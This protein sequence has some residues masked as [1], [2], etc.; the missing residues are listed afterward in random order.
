VVHHPDQLPKVL[1][2]WRH[3]LSTGEPFDL[4]FPLRRADGQ[5]RPFLTRVEPLRDNGGEILLWLGTN[6]DISEQ[7]RQEQLAKDSAERLRAVLTERQLLLER[8]RAVRAEAEHAGLLKDEFL[9]TLSHELRTPLNAILGWSELLRS[10]PIDSAAI[11]QGLEII[12]RNAHAQAQM[13]ADLLEMTR[14][15][16]GKVRL[17]LERVNLAFVL[18]EAIATV[19]PVAAAKEISIALQTL[20]FA[21]PIM[22]DPSRIRQVFWN[23]FSNAIKFT[24][25]AG[26]VQVVVK[27]SDSEVEVSV[28]DT[29]EGI[30][31]EFLPYVF[32]RFRQA[33]S[34]TA[35]RHGGLGLGLSIVRQLVELHGGS[36]R[37]DSPGLGL[38]ARFV[39]TFPIAAT[40]S[41]TQPFRA[42]SLS[43]DVPG[44]RSPDGQVDQ[45]DL[46][47]VRVLC[48]D[49][50]P[51]SRLLVEQLLRE[52]HADVVTATSAVEAIELIIQSPPDVLVSDIGMPVEDGYWL[53]NKSAV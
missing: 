49:D 45:F 1:E 19:R 43:I 34:S 11:S 38:G 41:P 20:P 10:Q 14:I 47:G 53:C 7:Q 48:V 21:G 12:E 35:R 46:T 31:A 3:S 6:T 40:L 22:G 8:E 28:T 9:T 15:V 42:E 18:E 27:Q 33:D 26:Q 17:D 44:M 39:V 4:V 32:D 16:T 25:Q 30:A 2:R 51:D 13:I 5:F 52:R 36:V 29:G 24:S 50:E 37:A 23:L